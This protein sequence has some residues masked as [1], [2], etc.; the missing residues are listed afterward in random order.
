MEDDA[1]VLFSKYF[2]ISSIGSFTPNSPGTCDTSPPI[3]LAPT[4]NANLFLNPPLETKA[5]FSDLIGFVASRCYP[6]IFLD[7]QLY[8]EL[9]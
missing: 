8:S 7:N 6:S 3:D 5:L 2:P 1:V 9:R 4:S